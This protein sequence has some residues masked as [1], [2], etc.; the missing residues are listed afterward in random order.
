M[1]GAFFLIFH[2]FS[3]VQAKF[4][5]V[6]TRSCVATCISRSWWN[7]VK[8]VTWQCQ[9]GTQC[10]N[11]CELSSSIV[12]VLTARRSPWKPAELWLSDIVQNM[13]LR[14]F[15]FSSILEVF[16]VIQHDNFQC[17]QTCLDA[18]MAA[19]LWQ[20]KWFKPSLHDILPSHKKF[21]VDLRP[22]GQCFQLQVCS[23]NHF[24]NH[25]SINACLNLKNCA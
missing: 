17:W 8:C 15:K 14:H 9:L 24:I 10:S 2:S 7:K 4:S 1:N 3:F 6:N 25:F 16:Y 21:N 12:A 20:Y 5:A 11:V 13:Q 23:Y 19:D 22:H 18:V